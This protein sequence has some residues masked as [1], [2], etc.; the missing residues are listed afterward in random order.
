M[1]APDL[2]Q[3]LLMLSSRIPYWG[4]VLFGA[5]LCFRHAGHKPR[6]VRL[7][8][9]ALAL[10]VAGSLTSYL[11]VPLLNSLGLNQ[12]G[13]RMSWWFVSGILSLPQAVGLGLLFWAI[14]GDFAPYEEPVYRYDDEQTQTPE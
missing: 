3:I 10:M 7:T 8:A 4:V 9:I 12:F 14:F 2:N 6:E 13:G 5:F 11:I 1:I